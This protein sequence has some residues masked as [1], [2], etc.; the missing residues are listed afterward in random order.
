MRDLE[1]VY[2]DYDS[3]DEPI[4]VPEVEEDDDYYD[5]Q[6]AGIH[7]IYIYIYSLYYINITLTIHRVE[8]DSRISC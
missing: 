6:T 8:Y 7:T 3:N 2:P 1:P 5:S 4:L